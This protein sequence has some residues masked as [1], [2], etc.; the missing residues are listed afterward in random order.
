MTATANKLKAADTTMMGVVHDALRRDLRRI[1]A[2]LNA[3]SAIGPERRRALSAHLEWVMDFLHHH[4]RGEDEGLWPLLRGQ[5]AEGDALLDQ[6]EADHSSIDPGIEQVLNAASRF[7]ADPADQ[8]RADKASDDLRAS[9][10]RLNEVLL[11]H[12]RREEDDAMPLVA[13]TLTN[14]QWNA[15]DQKHNVKGK[16]LRQLGQEGHW[17]MDSLDPT[18]YQVLVHLVP[19]PARLL[20]VKGFARSYRKA[21]A[22]RWGPDMPVEPLA[23]LA[24]P[25]ACEGGD[26]TI[27]STPSYAPES[28]ASTKEQL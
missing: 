26:G 27:R 18:R 8:T 23:S 22:L 4:H 11:P 7:A 25:A 9:L 17:L 16:S 28:T 6:M 5:T 19:P 3:G 15:W 12:L 2:T 14:A 1:D 24:G 13:A 20:I 10:N 21:C